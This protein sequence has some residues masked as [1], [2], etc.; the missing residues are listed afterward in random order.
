MDHALKNG[1]C[2]KKDVKKFRREMELAREHAEGLGPS[3]PYVFDSKYSKKQA[4]AGGR[5]RLENYDDDYG[6]DD[7]DEFYETLSPF[8]PPPSIF[9][10]G[11]SMAGSMYGG[12][13]MGS[14]RGSRR[15][16]GHQAHCGI[17]V[18]FGRARCSVH[19]RY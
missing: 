9:S 14:S 16:V 11:S 3:M 1:G 17:C 13:S 10:Q 5:M 19:G 18:E 2:A 4:K 8:V 12:R 15:P 6:D 7:D